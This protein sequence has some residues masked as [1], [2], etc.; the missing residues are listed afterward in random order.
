MR[1]I[2]I[3]TVACAGLAACQGERRP[4][5]GVCKPFPEAAQPAATDG[6]A[7]LE[8][9]LH[10]WGYTL[11]KGP[12]DAGMVA[13]AAVAA[14]TGPLTRWNQQSLAAAA[15]APEQ[16]QEGLSLLTGEPSSP[17]AEHRK[18]ASDRALFYVAQARAGSCKAPPRREGAPMTSPDK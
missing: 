14:C 15:A 1:N 4:V 12:D 9:C 10:R 16:S 11:A 8:D 3:V 18:F 7:V 13:D 2:L 5:A 6:A 17:I